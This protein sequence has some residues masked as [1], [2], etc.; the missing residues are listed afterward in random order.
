MT[1][2][3]ISEKPEHSMVNDE[4]AKLIAASADLALDETDRRIKTIM[5]NVKLAYFSTPNDKLI[6]IPIKRMK[7]AIAAHDPDTFA[8]SIHGETGAGKSTLFE[9]RLKDEPS[10]RPVPDGYGNDLYPVLYIKAPSKATM[11]DLGEELLDAMGYPTK[12]RKHESDLI[13]DVRNALRRRGTRVVLIDEFQHVLDAPK[14]K[15]P[16]HVADSIKNLLQNP[17]WPI[18]I[19]L[20][21]LPEIKEVALRDPKDQFLRRVDDF[22]LQT[23]SLKADAKFI[24]NV[25]KELVV[26]RAGLRMPSAVV[27]DFIERLMY[28]AHFRYGMVMKIIYHAIEDAL[29][30]DLGEVTM[31][32]WEEGYR[33]LVNGDA[34]PETNVFA[35]DN[36]RS[37]LRPVNRRGEFGPPSVR[38]A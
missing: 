23:L 17:K 29:E 12:K 38:A 16:S 31:L 9:Q 24:A 14:V 35:A 8:V 36:W 32:C 2:S 10:F 25:I 4:I 27:P 19:V 33:R 26:N 7:R 22:A 15:G 37:I 1:R 21:G 28:G 6:D 18:F 3:R 30:N 5:K 34:V 20:M 11:V 13:R